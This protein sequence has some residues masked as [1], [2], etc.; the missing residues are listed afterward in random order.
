ME[1]KHTPVMLKEVLEYLRPGPGQIFIDGTLGG[2]GYALA[3]ANAVGKDGRVLGID[4]D[5]TA[6]EHVAKLIANNKLSNIRLYNGNFKNID[7]IYKE[8]LKER[9]SASLHGIVLDLG[10]SSAQLKSQSRGFSF[11]LDAPLD[12]AFGQTTDDR[13]QT[14]DSRQQTT[15]EIVNQ[16]PQWELEKIIKEYGE[17]RYAKSIAKRIVGVRKERNIKTTK[18]LVEIIKQAV[19]S[20]YR[21]G[22]IHP[23]TR[24]FQAL[25]IATNDEL[26]NLRAALD[27]AVKILSPGGKIAIV[28]YHS[29][30]DRIVKR[31]FKKEAR[32]CICPPAAPV[33]VC[34]HKALIKIITKKIVKPG[35]EE[36]KANPKARSAK[37][38]VA[39]R[40]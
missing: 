11:Q 9:Q 27:A 16:T 15:E 32:D 29:L 37:L 22:R 25:R 33:C 38:R 34:G 20:S 5:K 8:F 35:Q 13:Q 28:S 14:A 31:F 10:L 19:P 12:M 24:T 1:Y 6:I 3:L 2:G 17:E 30:E 36:I 23:A 26:G 40:V 21:H 4:L 39:E 7:K 18:E